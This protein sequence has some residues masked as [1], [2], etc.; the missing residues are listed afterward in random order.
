MKILEYNHAHM[1]EMKIWRKE[2]KHIN[3]KEIAEKDKRY[4]ELHSSQ[5]KSRHKQWYEENKRRIIL[6]RKMRRN[7]NLQTKLSCKLRSR[8]AGILN[9]KQVSKLHHTFDLVGCTPAF[10]ASYIRGKLNG[11]MTEQDLL[12]GKV[13]IDHIKPCA[14]FD[15]TKEEEQRK[16]FHY[17][18][19]QPLWAVDNLRKNAKIL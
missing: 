6:R 9:L 11:G 5:I 10:L 12:N 13:H 4:R 16:C 17:T 15:L 2:Y 18:N 3:K 19:L 14:A 8:F 7:T 1:E